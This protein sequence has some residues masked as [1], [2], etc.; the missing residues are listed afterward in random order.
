MKLG[1]L[2]KV[3][4]NDM[5]LIIK[6]PGPKDNRFF[7]Q[8]GTIVGIYDPAPW[9]KN[10]PWYEVLFPAGYYDARASAL[11]VI[12]NISLK[13]ISSSLNKSESGKSKSNFILDSS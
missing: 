11:E 9:E 4:K 12:G 2:V 10:N 8:I 5:S 1:D 6:N 7:N 3:I 13:D